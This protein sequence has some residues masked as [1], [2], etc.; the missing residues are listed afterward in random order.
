MHDLQYIPG[1]LYN[2]AMSNV[3]RCCTADEQLYT[4]EDAIEKLGF[5][6]FQVLVTL[7]SGLLW[8]SVGRYLSSSVK[9]LMS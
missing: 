4:V 1:H 8:V 7:F 5:G 9:A 6:F 3:L 2:C